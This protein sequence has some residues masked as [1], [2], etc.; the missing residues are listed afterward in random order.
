MKK[1]IWKFDKSSQLMYTLKNM[2]RNTEIL[3][4]K[5]INILF[6]VINTIWSLVERQKQTHIYSQH[7]VKTFLKFFIF[8]FISE[9][10]KF[11]SHYIISKFHKNTHKKQKIWEKTITD[12]TIAFK[13]ML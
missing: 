4:T 1:K 5:H 13:W 6:N 3:E 7:T 9:N 10:F 2:K 12:T 11:W 8:L